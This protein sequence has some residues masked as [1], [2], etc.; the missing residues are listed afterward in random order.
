MNS[1][2]MLRKPLLIILGPTAVGKTDLAIEIAQAVQGEIISTDSRQIYRLMDI[3]TAKPTPQQ[4]AAAAHHLLDVVNP[5]E[6]LALAQYQQMAYATIT[7]IHERGHVP[8]LAGGTGQYITAVIEGWTIP[9]VPPNDKL[10]TELESYASEQGAAALHERLHQLDATAA[11]NIDYR[12]VRRV[13]RA[14]EVCLET[15]QAISDLQRKRPPPYQIM[16]Y[17]LT[18]DRE[19]LYERADRRI[20]QMMEQGFLA[21]VQHLLDA[22]YSRKLPSMSGLGYAQLA[23]HL[24]DDYPLQ[25]AVVDTKHATHDFIRRQYTWFRGHDSNILWHNIEQLDRAALIEA[26][27]R[28]VQEQG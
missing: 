4:Q 9:E 15:G 23:T 6:N 19:R 24:L 28:W 17:G 5:D 8:I 25:D 1:F 22:G 10:R 7:A 21:E 16:S 12:N 26:S 3:G 2:I 14:L 27:A 18:M 11:A 20:E 13:V